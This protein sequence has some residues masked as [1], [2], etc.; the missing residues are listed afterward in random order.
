MQMDGM[1][2]GKN[3][4]PHPCGILPQKCKNNLCKESES[5]KNRNRGDQLKFSEHGDGNMY[6][7]MQFWVA[8]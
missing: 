4:K 5:C 6:H 2:S 3:V 7:A 1:E 8:T